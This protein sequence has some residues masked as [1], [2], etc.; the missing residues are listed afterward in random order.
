MKY[1]DTWRF[2][3]VQILRFHLAFIVYRYQVAFNENYN[4]VTARLAHAQ[5]RLPLAF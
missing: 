1:V 5:L 2:M 4:S 3:R